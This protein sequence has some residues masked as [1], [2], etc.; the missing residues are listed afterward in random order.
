M[1]H[2]EKELGQPVMEQTSKK[3]VPEW[4]RTQTVSMTKAE[5]LTGNLHDT[6]LYE[7]YHTQLLEI[8]VCP[9]IMVSLEKIHL[10]SPV[11]KVLQCSKDAYVALGHHITILVPEVPYV[12][13]QIQSIRFRRKIVQKR[14]KTTLAFIRILD[15]EPQMYV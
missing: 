5:S 8:A 9:H 14:N 7:T 10:H 4:D 1:Q 11:H 12:T 2:T 15:F 6:W 13:E 3:P